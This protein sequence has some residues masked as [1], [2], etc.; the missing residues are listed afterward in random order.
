MLEMAIYRAPRA[1][2]PA[3]RKIISPV[4]RQHMAEAMRLLYGN[5]PGLV[6]DEALAE[7]ERLWRADAA[8]GAVQSE[9]LLTAAPSPRGATERAPTHAVELNLN[10]AECC[11]VPDDGSSWPTPDAGNSDPVPLVDSA[12]GS[13]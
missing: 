7:R 5:T 10:E 11:S 13:Y 9:L 6:G 4:A 3:G 8:N 2:H 12:A 1:P